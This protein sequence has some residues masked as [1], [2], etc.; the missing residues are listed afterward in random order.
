MPDFTDYVAT[1]RYLCDEKPMQP[2][3][4]QRPDDTFGTVLGTTKATILLDGKQMPGP[5]FEYAV[6]SGKDY[7]N[8]SLSGKVLDG[9]FTKCPHACGE[10]TVAKLREVC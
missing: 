7:P 8:R 5:Y 9:V 1:P 2:F 3:C 6:T 4:F 10:T